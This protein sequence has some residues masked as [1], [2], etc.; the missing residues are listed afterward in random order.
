M[1]PQY[2][3]AALVSENK[4]L[5]HPASVDSIPTSANTEDHVSMGSIAARKALKIIENAENV[6]AIEYLNALQGLTFHKMNAGK[7]TQAARECLQKQVAPITEDR[8]YV[9]D[10]QKIREMM[11]DGAI[12]KE[13]EKKIGKLK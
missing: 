8:Y 1:I 2:T 11:I 6:V 12:V 3:A 10:M 4:V 7:G 13:V 9:P 5:A